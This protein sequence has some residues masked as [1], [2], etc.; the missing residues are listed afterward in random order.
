MNRAAAMYTQK[1]GFLLVG[2]MIPRE[3]I[4]GAMTA[5]ALDEGLAFFD[6]GDR[7]EK[8]LKVMIDALAIGLVQ[9]ANRAT[10]GILVQNLRFW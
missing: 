8:N 2:R 1:P 10:S 7:N 5:F 9:T 6:S 4:L 3:F